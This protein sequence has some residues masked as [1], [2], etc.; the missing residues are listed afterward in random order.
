MRN[1]KKRINID[2]L[3][4]KSSSC[5]SISEIKDQLRKISFIKSKIGTDKSLISIKPTFHNDQSSLFYALESPF[6][7]D[8]RNKNSNKLFSKSKSFIQKKK[9]S[10]ILLM[11]KQENKEKN[12]IKKEVLKDHSKVKETYLKKNY[13]K[14]KRSLKVFTNFLTQFQQ[15]IRKHMRI[16]QSLKSF[17]SGMY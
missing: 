3:L 13:S 6:K 15:R 10:I 2:N 5:F 12:R 4:P 8:Y 17:Y 9:N 11:D 1:D 7:I 14:H 16:S